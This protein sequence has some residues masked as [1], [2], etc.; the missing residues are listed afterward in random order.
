MLSGATTVS[1]EQGKSDVTVTYV[2][3]GEVR[4]VTAKAVIMATPKFITRRLVAGLPEAQQEA[5]HKIRYA[6]YPVVNAIFNLDVNKPVFNGGY[7][8]WCPGNAF[9]DVIV[10]DWVIRNRPLERPGLQHSH[11]LHPAARSRARAAV[12][13][14]RR[15]RSGRQGVARLA[16]AAARIKQRSHGG[17]YLPARTPNV[18]GHTGHLH[19]ADPGRTAVHGSHLF[20]EHGFDRSGVHDQRR[21]RRFPARHR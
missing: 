14:R 15:P 9:T 4:A 2:H 3:Q 17:A 12:N 13:R 10:A 6:P 16:E 5:M 21:Y 19:E 20:C 7:D 18:H 11:V 1:V 8:T